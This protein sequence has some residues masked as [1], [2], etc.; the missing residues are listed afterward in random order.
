MSNTKPERKSNFLNGVIIVI[1]D[2]NT[3]GMI[4]VCNT[5]IMNLKWCEGLKCKKFTRES[6]QNPSSDKNWEGRGPKSF[7]NFPQIFFKMS[8]FA[9]NIRYPPTPTLNSCVYLIL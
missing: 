5:G 6:G 7:D 2:L 3:C 1:C 9:Q 4:N 8:I